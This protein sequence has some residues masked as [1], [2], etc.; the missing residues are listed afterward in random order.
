MK[1]CNLRKLS[2][3]LIF[4]FFFS[5]LELHSQCAP[6]MGDQISY[7]NG[8]WIG[9]VYSDGNSNSLPSNVFTTPYRGFI[10]LPEVFDQNLGIGEL[11][12]PNLCGTYSDNYAIRLKMQKDYSPGYYKITAGANNGFRL[13]IDGGITFLL[14]EWDFT[15]TS[16]TERSTF[17]YLSGVYEIVLE[18]FE[19]LSDARMNF[20][21]SQCGIPSTAP[22]TITGDP[23]LCL[24]ESQVLTAIGGN[25]LTGTVYEW[26]TGSVIGLN[27]I[28]GAQ[29]AS[30]TITPNNTTTYWVRRIDPAPCTFTTEGISFTVNVFN[31][32]VSPSTITG[33]NIICSG[34]NTILQSG[35]L[36][37]NIQW[38]FSNDNIN[39]Q[40]IADETS[41]VL[42]TSNLNSNT[43]FR[44]RVTGSSYCAPVFS[45][46]YL[47]TV[48]SPGSTGTIQG[49]SNICEGGGTFDLNLNSFSG[50]IQWE[51]S[52]DAINFQPISGATSSTLTVTSFTQDTYYRV[53][54]TVAGC[55]IVYSETHLV[56]YIPAPQSGTIIGATPL[57]SGPNSITLQASGVVGAI[58]WQVSTDGTNFSDLPNENGTQWIGTN[59]TTS[60]Y[61]RLKITNSFCNTVF[62]NSVFVPVS[63]STSMGT[64]SGNLT[65]CSGSN[66][67]TLTITGATG[68]LQWQSSLDNITFSDIPGATAATLTTSNLT[69][70]TFYRV[71]LGNINCSPLFSNAI[72][73]TVT[74][75]P[76]AGTITGSNSTL[77]SAVNAT[78]L[79][80]T[81]SIGSI[82]WQTSTDN[83][84]FVTI[85]GANS[86]TLEVNN[87]ASTRYYRVLVSNGGC[88]NVLSNVYTL[89][90]VGPTAGTIS[91]AT[92][93]C[94]TSNNFTLVLSGS[95][96]NVQWQ[97]S[98]DNITFTPIPGANSTSLTVNN[99]TTATYYNVA[100]S[101]NSCPLV[102]S[103]PVLVN[104]GI[105]TAA[106]T[107]NGGGVTVVGGAT[108][109]STTLTVSGVSGN[110]QWQS[111][112]DNV[113][114]TSISGANGVSYIASNLLSTTFFRVQV[115]NG[116]CTVTSPSV[117]IN[118]CSPTG[119][120]T[121][122]G[123]GSTWRAYVYAPNS[124]GAN[125]ANA[126][127]TYQ[128]FYTSNETFDT[129]FN[130]SLASTICG[131]ANGSTYHNRNV[132]VRY[133]LTR[134]FPNSNYVF[135]VGSVGSYRLS[136]DGGATW[137]ISNWNR[138]NAMAYESN[139]ASIPLSGNV[140]MVIE[141]VANG[142]LTPRMYFT[143]CGTNPAITAPTSI[144]GNLNMQVGTNTTLFANGGIGTIFQWGTGS[145]P[146]INVL[147][148]DT[149][150][151][152]VSPTT[153]TTYWV[154]RFDPACNIYTSAIFATVVINNSTPL[155]P[156]GTTT[157][158][159]N[160][161]WI[162]YVYGGQANASWPNN[163][164]QA[165]IAPF[166]YSGY[167][168]T[169]TPNFNW[170]FCPG[171]AVPTHFNQPTLSI[172]SGYFN[173]RF[174]V[175]YLMNRNF[176]PGYYTFTITADDG[177]RFSVD[178]GTT[179]VIDRWV[180]T[181][182]GTGTTNT[183]AVFLNGSTNLVLDYNGWGS[184]G[185]LN[186]SF[187]GCTNFSTP[188]TSIT[189]PNSVCI[190]QNITLTASGGNSGSNGRFQWGTGSVIGQN[191]LP[192]ITQS[193]SVS[194]STTTTYWV[195][196]LDVGGNCRV[197]SG[198]GTN[199][200]TNPPITT[201][202]FTDGV[203]KTITIDPLSVSGSIT[204]G[205][206]TVC[207]GTNSTT[208][209]LVGSVGSIQWQQST[210]N[211]TFSNIIGAN[212]SN[213]T[214]NN[215]N[216]TTF[217]RALVTSGSCSSVV[218]NVV[219]I[220]VL[221]NPTTGV[222]TG[223]QSVCIS[224]NSV[225]LEAIGFSGGSL[226]WQ[227]STNNITFSDINGATNSSLV[228]SDLGVTTYY[229]IRIS[230]GVCPAVFSSV[231]T[232]SVFS[233][234]IAGSISLGGTS[235]LCGNSN[236]YSLSATGFTGSI[237]WQSSI[238]NISFTDISGANQA[239]YNGTNLGVTTFFRAR[240]SN[241]V[242]ADEF[243]N[244]IQVIVVPQPVA[245]SINGGG[246]VCFGS[247]NTTLT[248]TGSLGSIQW[249]S[250]IDNVN[251][252]SISGA[253]GTSLNITNLTTT[254]YYRVVVSNGLCSSVQSNVATI[255]VAPIAVS[256]FISGAGNF[257]SGSTVNL[258][259]AGSVGSI[260][261]QV[262]TDNVSFTS[263]PGATQN[264]LTLPNVTSTAFY[265]AIVSS[266]PCTSATTN[267]VL[268]FVNPQS[269]S[270]LI[271]GATSWCTNQNA[272]TLTLTG[273][274]GSIQWQMSTDNTTFT[275]IVGA[276]AENLNVINLSATRYYRARV[277]NGVC[278]AT[279]TPVVAITINQPTVAGALSTTSSGTCNN[280]NTGMTPIQLSGH[281][282]DIL[283][284]Q[285]ADNA[286]FTQN[287]SNI[288]WTFPTLTSNEVGVLT[289][290]KF[291]RAVIQ[292]GDCDILFT[293][294]V[295]KVVPPV[296]TFNGSWSGVPNSSTVVVISQNLTLTTNLSF[297]SCQIS[298]NA[299][300]TIPSNVTL[301]LQGDLNVDNGSNLIVQNNGSLVQVSD[302]AVNTGNI[303]FR[304]NTSPLKQFDYT[305]F[306]SPLA[307][308]TM[309]NFM[310]N[311]MFYTFDPLINNW[312]LKTAGT[313]NP[314]GLGFIAR[315]N[316]ALNFSTAQV[317]P[318]QLIG[319]PNNG[320]IST[321]LIKSTGTFNLIGNPYPSAIDI[322]RFLEDPSNA[323]LVEGT[324]YLWTHNTAIANVGG[325]NIYVYTADDYAKY[326]LTGG[327][328][329]A[330]PALTG[331]MTPTGK[332]AAG[333]SFFIEANSSLAPGNY[334]VTFNNSMRIS[335]NNSQFFRSSSATPMAQQSNQK[336]RIW[337]SVSNSQGAYNETLIGYVTHATNGYDGK[338]DGKTMP[339]SNV[340]ALYSLLGQDKLA[341]QGRAL[342]FDT[343]D[344]VPLGFSTTL[345]GSFQVTLQNFD[346]LFTQQDVFL[347]DNQTG[348]LH[349]LKDGNYV[350]SSNA[351]TFENRFEIHYRNSVLSSPEISNQEILIYVN[352]LIFTVVS[353][354]HRLNQITLYD[355][356][357]R[358]IH[359]AV[360]IQN[361]TYQWEV[362][363][364]KHQTVIAKI[365][366]ENG[367]ET[368]QKLLCH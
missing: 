337:L 180:W 187:V 201:D 288:N 252:N 35:I 277:T 80:V 218:S 93:V 349:N 260:Q 6:I 135:V 342:P 73:V 263:L 205:G 139:S 26:G 87:L 345:N 112:T 242:C 300:V 100:V 181:S 109:N 368:V 216:Q 184:C 358:L 165:F 314:A 191:V 291:F 74:P 42:V 29:S 229:R 194:P 199:S 142:N 320:V 255:Q 347:K 129:N 318:V 15:N 7:G 3:S 167:V 95:I 269:I 81:G 46:S 341:I 156:N 200:T 328:G 170:N 144:I 236:T 219:N 13:S 254:T 344:I 294:P 262:S 332:I 364:L 37:G 350:F 276:T 106:G 338:Y 39:F 59:L 146:G 212:N 355:L 52:T 49:P 138:A 354:D 206:N 251:F 61:F 25:E 363:K 23:F 91:G 141:Y 340:V 289:S 86:S 94:P 166:K 322:D 361:T 227:S 274:S 323:S 351:G 309:G 310:S 69:V 134:N 8:S 334:N 362:E 150:S 295:Q 164:N 9:Y 222:I 183:Y 58:Q 11:S 173:Q 108:L 1:N 317:I 130:A 38:Q 79:T 224:G 273:Y 256:G 70:T 275:S 215:L 168:T 152:I 235:T 127:D 303:T 366:L 77:C 96:G 14:D 114:F 312:S 188:P 327:V 30:I 125:P 221:P 172:T 99:L 247:N 53:A 149:N 12:G 321:P 122:Y 325:T 208:L 195:R 117:A 245:G 305:Y 324:I 131:S 279:F 160:G 339:T 82:Q 353:T 169:A 72:I 60:Q 333:Q 101:N 92:T 171:G 155:M 110:I 203:F 36:I 296:V 151:I 306:S 261:W 319:T 231:H 240:I 107:I 50:T 161:V 336:H 220:T 186:F 298:N 211:V 65:V 315:A 145:T 272:T 57:C 98:T 24:G 104:V 271:S 202:A 22:T 40:D 136:L 128:G 182:S 2:C 313:I 83:I 34:S 264:Q 54:V 316:N 253:N 223:T 116:V 18:H 113:T 281:V 10:T 121:V 246:S 265:R 21:I 51:S 119:D 5:L 190:G 257:C 302:T 244:V 210:N 71:R 258:N 343:N 178:G 103:S 33:G 248:V 359:K 301:T 280:V 75:S 176:A 68:A 85:S 179:W 286:A 140:N 290:N 230:N 259:L 266:S 346:G 204:G 285:S 16:Y 159:G 330:D 307:N 367:V 115:S 331:G 193:I 102:T 249:Q 352:D 124:G 137:V 56:N 293:A 209:N 143:F 192:F 360:D 233:Q 185:S 356:T 162:G 111:S 163:P 175:R 97:S 126:F 63:P 43:Y 228:L 177:V 66:S 217:Y 198:T 105:P 283:M 329:T 148:G 213:L 76:Q 304:R 147:P 28:P 284:W 41:S 64:V 153:N 47:V 214:V 32:P 297:C 292:N 365:V 88:I 335:G 278:P 118:V 299:T 17:I 19:L 133:R 357:G 232:V 268:V 67:Q 120:P 55:S 250:S 243:S 45:A 189:S 267:S 78:T 238:D 207:A 84:T 31:P 48:Q 20:S 239:S 348:A 90:Y 154:R 196:R 158:Y 326:N 241:G 62:S 226:Q 132:A 311:S 234:P 157:E 44:V 308:Q 287:V 123:T 27:V 237:Q 197:S 270:G 4:I 225:S 282:G 174:S 89:S